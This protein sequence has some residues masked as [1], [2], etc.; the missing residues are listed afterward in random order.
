VLQITHL[1]S[2]FE[3]YETEDEAL[4]SMPHAVR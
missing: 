1:A 4:R 2:V 3:I